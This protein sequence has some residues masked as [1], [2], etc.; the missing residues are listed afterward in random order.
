MNRFQVLGLALASTTATFTAPA[1][2]QATAAP[3][4]GV[5][6]TVAGGPSQQAL[7]VRVENQGIRIAVCASLPCEAGASAGGPGMLVPWPADAE[8]DTRNAQATAVTLHGGAKLVR[9]DIPTI[10]PGSAW[11]LLAAAPRKSEGAEPHLVWQGISGAQQGEYGERH[12]AAVLLDG[13]P[14]GPVRVLVGEHREDVT[15]C[16]RPALVAARE[17]DPTT[18]S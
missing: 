3:P 13:A 18:F 15:M 16:G 17:V 12:G 11:V 9:V 1:T 14:T 5:S 2:G 6:L 4:T 7:A 8:L 10:A